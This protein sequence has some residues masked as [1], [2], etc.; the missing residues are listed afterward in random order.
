MD[1]LGLGSQLLYVV[2]EDSSVYFNPTFLYF[3]KTVDPDPQF[4]WTVL[5]A[6]AA[7]IAW[8]CQCA[9]TCFFTAS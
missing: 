2:S 8:V 4:E 9:I 5:Q 1:I 6:S 3:L 7:F